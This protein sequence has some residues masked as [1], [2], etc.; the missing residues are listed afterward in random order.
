MC[1]IVKSTERPT[2]NRR[3]KVLRREKDG[4]LMSPCIH[5]HGFGTFWELNRPNCL[6]EEKE[7]DINGRGFHVFTYFEDAES[8]AREIYANMAPVYRYHYVVVDCECFGFVASGVHDE[9]GLPTEIWE[10]VK[11]ISI[12]KEY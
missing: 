11:P 6:W 3:Y 8:F 12:L 1:M 5:V 10:V 9:T 2:T 4:P 7:E